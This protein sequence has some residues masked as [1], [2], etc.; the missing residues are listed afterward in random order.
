MG[1]TQSF[2]GLVACRLLLGIFEA[3]LFPGIYVRHY[4]VEFF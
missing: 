4:L 3:G 1:L 2:A